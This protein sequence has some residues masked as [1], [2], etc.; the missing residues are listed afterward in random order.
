ML[1]SLDRVPRAR[2][3]IKHALTAPSNRVHM[4]PPI[5]Y[6]NTTPTILN[7]FSIRHSL[8]SG[9]ET[10]SIPLRTKGLIN[11]TFD[12][13]AYIHISPGYENCMMPRGFS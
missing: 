5:F 10:R 3:S 4:Y 7:D 1:C 12:S 9:C 13:H 2:H 11:L 8:H 6:N